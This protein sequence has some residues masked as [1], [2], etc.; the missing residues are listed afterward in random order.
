[1][2]GKLF[3]FLAC[4]TAAAALAGFNDENLRSIHFLR[5]LSYTQLKDLEGHLRDLSRTK[6]Q[7]R[8][9]VAQLNKQLP[10]ESRVGVVGVRSEVNSRFRW[11]PLTSLPRCRRTSRDRLASST[12]S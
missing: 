5:A 9:K 2:F 7:I 11:A 8:H 6:G 10:E 4:A 3:V 12:R 1:M